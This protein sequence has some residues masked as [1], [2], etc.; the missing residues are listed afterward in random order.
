MK[1]ESLMLSDSQGAVGGAQ[2]DEGCLPDNV[3]VSHVEQASV[4]D[5]LKY[6]TPE[7]D[8]ARYQKYGLLVNHLAEKHGVVQF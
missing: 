2:G 6:S 8:S 1:L 7:A 4:P 5:V 3:C